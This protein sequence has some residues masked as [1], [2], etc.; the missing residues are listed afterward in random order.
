MNSN[1]NKADKLLFF[2]FPFRDSVGMNVGVPFRIGEIYSGFYSIYLLLKKKKHF[3]IPHI[4]NNIYAIIVLLTFNLF[5]VLIVSILNYDRIDQPFLIKY[6]IRNCLTIFLMFSIWKVPLSYNE[7]LIEWSAKWNIILQLIAAFFFFVLGQRIYM[8]SLTSIWDIQTSE[9]GGFEFPRYSGTTAESG[10]LAPL[11]AYPLLYFAY[12]HKD[13]INKIFLIIT[14]ILLMISLSTFNYA[15]LLFAFC[16]YLYHQNRNKLICSLVLICLFIVT[17][18]IV[19]SFLQSGSLLSTILEANMK[20][21]IGYLTFGT[22]G[23]L[24]WSANDRNE[25]LLNAFNFFINGNFMELLLGHGTGAYSYLAS[26]HSAVLVE[27]VEEAY[28]LYLSTLTDRGLIGFVTYL[29]II[30][31]IYRI[32]TNNM[33]SNTIWFAIL[34]QLIHYFL[35]GGMWLYYVWQEVVFLVGFEKYRYIKKEV[36]TNKN[37]ED[38]IRC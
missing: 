28:N 12:Y 26:H 3:I 4:D 27:N 25:H 29:I 2:F 33:I 24:D 21:G 31:K 20:K 14:I 35:V 16:Y 7:K 34:V 18:Y 36:N 23:E 11:L 13:K 9:Y 22:Y 17:I 19:L 8:N 5:I 38:R 30:F 37:Y 15:I 1:K 6:V 32:K 10:F